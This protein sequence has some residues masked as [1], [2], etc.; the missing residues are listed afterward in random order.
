MLRSSRFKS[1]SG[2][3]LPSVWAVFSSGC[4]RAT[5]FIVEGNKDEGI[6][7]ILVVT[8]FVC[9]L[10]SL[11][12]KKG[13]F[14][15][16]TVICAA[17]AG[18]VNG[19][20]SKFSPAAA[21][22]EVV[23]NN[24]D[25]NV[26]RYLDRYPSGAHAAEARG[27]LVESA[28][29]G[30]YRAQIRALIRRGRNAPKAAS[31][32]T[33]LPAGPGAVIHSGR[34]FSI[35]EKDYGYEQ[36]EDGDERHDTLKALFQDRLRSMSPTQA[37][38]ELTSLTHVILLDREERDL[39]LS[40]RNG[41]SAFRVDWNVRVVDLVEGVVIAETKLEGGA[42]PEAVRSSSK[43][44]YGDVPRAE[45]HKWLESLPRASEP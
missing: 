9:F 38:N 23:R 22:R 41:A 6:I 19:C 26:R 24:T 3:F 29:V 10:L 35:E 27:R 21:W 12:T 14:F 39:G 4:G 43:G 34:I 20:V 17:L 31:L 45:F 37:K 40:Y 28:N 33:S 25:E 7:G 16:V 32:K 2:W 42:P 30:D 13:S 36:P 44:G 1:L 8:A 5:D 11:L 18:S 15:A